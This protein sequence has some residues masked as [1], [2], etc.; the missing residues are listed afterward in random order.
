MN[1]FEKIDSKGKIRRNYKTHRTRKKKRK[2]YCEKE[3]TKITT[4]AVS[5]F[6]QFESALLLR[7]CRIPLRICISYILTATDW[8]PCLRQRRRLT[9]W[10]RR[11]LGPTSPAC[12]STAPLPLLQLRLLRLPPLPPNSLL[13]SV[14][15]SLSLFHFFFFPL[16]SIS[17]E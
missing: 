12:A 13:L 10:W 8:E 15:D 5:V 11:P 1:K 17:D 7:G 4:R 3:A 16:I 14:T 2:E 9:T 6:V